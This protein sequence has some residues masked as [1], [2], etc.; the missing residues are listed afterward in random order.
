MLADKEDTR[1][2]AGARHPRLQIGFETFVLAGRA[3]G[4]D[5]DPVQM[6]WEKRAHGVDEDIRA[7]LMADPAEAAG[8]FLV[9]RQADGCLRCALVGG[10]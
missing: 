6:A 10:R 1:L 2:K 3:A 5:R 7:L 4:D 9:R 8:D